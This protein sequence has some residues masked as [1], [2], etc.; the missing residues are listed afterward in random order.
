MI[1]TATWKEIMIPIPLFRDLVGHLFRHGA[2]MYINKNLQSHR[3]FMC[4]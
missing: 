1:N 4:H 3:L 2:D